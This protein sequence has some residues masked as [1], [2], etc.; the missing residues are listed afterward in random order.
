MKS[1][2]RRPAIDVPLH[3]VEDFERLERLIACARRAKRR[4]RYRMVLLVVKGWEAHVIAAAR[5][6]NRRSE[7]QWFSRDRGIE[8]LAPI[9]FKGHAPRLDPSRRAE[10][11]ALAGRARPRAMASARWGHGGAGDSRA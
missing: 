6:S 2:A 1:L 9:K 10:F 4:D 11:I 3:G 8:C 7:Q 5:A